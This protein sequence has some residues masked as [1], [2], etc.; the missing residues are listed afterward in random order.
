MAKALVGSMRPAGITPNIMRAAANA[1]VLLD[2]RHERGIGWRYAQ[3]LGQILVEHEAVIPRERSVQEV[4][5]EIDPEE[6][7]KVLADAEFAGSVATR[8]VELDLQ[9]E[10]E[11]KASVSA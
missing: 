8:I 7:D 10:A 9:F 11:E 6:I 4:T 5:E 2:R 1:G 3:G